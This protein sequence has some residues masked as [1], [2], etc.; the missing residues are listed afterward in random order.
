MY[1]SHTYWVVKKEQE[2]D[3]GIIKRTFISDTLGFRVT[4]LSTPRCLTP[5]NIHNPQKDLTGSIL[6]MGIPP[7]TPSPLVIS[8][9]SWPN[10]V[11]FHS[12]STH[13]GNFKKEKIVKISLKVWAVHQMSEDLREEELFKKDGSDLKTE[14]GIIIG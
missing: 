13:T 5:Y 2:L 6:Q 12:G 11:V 1:A 7:F 3:L 4:L 14:S 9:F 8:S 10:P